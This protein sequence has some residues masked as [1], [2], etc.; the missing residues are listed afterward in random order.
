M[1]AEPYRVPEMTVNNSDHTSFIFTYLSLTELNKWLC[2]VSNIISLQFMESEEWRIYYDELYQNLLSTLWTPREWILCY[3]LHWKCI[4]PVMS[5]PLT[6]ICYLWSQIDE[7]LQCALSHWL[8]KFIRH[9]SLSNL[10][11]VCNCWC[12]DRYFSRKL[13]S[14]MGF[15][16]FSMAMLKCAKG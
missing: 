11:Q 4:K 1:R 3:P 6:W 2:A 16:S 5:L 10:D 13:N 15:I 7:D 14:V 9:V 12:C 8:L